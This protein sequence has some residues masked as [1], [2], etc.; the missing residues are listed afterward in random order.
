MI[1]YLNSERLFSN[2]IYRGRCRRQVRQKEF[3]N[4]GA[5]FKSVGNS[6]KSGVNSVGNSMKTGF[7]NLKGKF[8][9]KNTTPSVV[10]GKTK[11]VGKTDLQGGSDVTPVVPN[12]VKQN[13]PGT[14]VKVDANAGIQTQADQFLNSQQ[15]QSAKRNQGS[16]QS[17]NQNSKKFEKQQDLLNKADQAQNILDAGGN[18]YVMGAKDVGDIKSAVNNANN[19]ILGLDKSSGSANPINQNSYQGQVASK[20][21]AQNLGPSP[22]DIKQKQITQEK[23]DR[24]QES[25]NAQK[26]LKDRLA[27]AKENGSLEQFQNARQQK[28]QTPPPYNPTPPPYNP[29]KG[30]TGNATNTNQNQ[31]WWDKNSNKIGWTIGIGGTAAAAYGV[32][33]LSQDDDN[34]SSPGPTTGVYTGQ[35]SMAAQGY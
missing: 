29:N 31:S 12:T 32:H 17:L 16:Q 8:G 20:A 33:K 24:Q 7:N 21:D 15:V 30:N 1:V 19:G 26:A 35:G 14:N 22:A 27:Q 13:V 28:Q 11:R 23:F 5:F 25:E 4:I 2:N 6:V 9:P 34:N 3:V 18:T 10:S